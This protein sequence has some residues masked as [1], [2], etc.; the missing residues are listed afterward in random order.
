M[1]VDVI[2]RP[3]PLLFK[4][5]IKVLLWNYR[6]ATNPHF[7]FHL[8]DL[9]QVHKPQL[10]VISETRVGGEREK[11]LAENLGFPNVFMVELASYA[12]GMWLL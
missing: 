4:P 7:R 9:H 1:L 6:G 10:V 2:S 5:P 8:F 11:S 12:G 3:P